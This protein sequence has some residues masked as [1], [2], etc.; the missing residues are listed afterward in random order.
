MDFEDDLFNTAEEKRQLAEELE[1]KQLL[2]EQKEE[3]KRVEVKSVEYKKSEL[4]VQVIYN[5]VYLILKDPPLYAWHDPNYYS[6]NQSFTIQLIDGK[7]YINKI[8]NM[9]RGTYIFTVKDLSCPEKSRHKIKI[10]FSVKDPQS[11]QLKLLENAVKDATE[12]AR[13]MATA[14]G[15]TTGYAGKNAINCYFSSGKFANVHFFS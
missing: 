13:V 3:P 2:A 6:E 1:L 9:F 14:A 12:K 7:V 8:A 15:C 11:Y 5:L 4:L 10:S